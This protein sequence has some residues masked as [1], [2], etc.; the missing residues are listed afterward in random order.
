MWPSCMYRLQHAG[1]AT[2]NHGVLRDSTKMSIVAGHAALITGQ[3]THRIDAVPWVPCLG[4]EIGCWC[5]MGCCNS[6]CSCFDLRIWHSWARGM[7]QL[8]T[9]PTPAGQRHEARRASNPTSAGGRRCR[10]C[11]RGDSYG[12]VV[13]IM[14]ACSALGG[15]VDRRRDTAAGLSVCCKRAWQSVAASPHRCQRPLRAGP[16]PHCLCR[17]DRESGTASAWHARIYLHRRTCQWAACR[18]S[19]CPDPLHTQA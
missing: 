2:C 14:P 6:I 11:R 7:G 3:K 5:W 13:G 8:A 16:F 17:L 12:Y 15:S 1:R 10:R 4:F 18:L 9:W 19:L